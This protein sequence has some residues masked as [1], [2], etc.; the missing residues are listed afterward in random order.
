MS[1]PINSTY[2]LYQVNY[3]R[4]F[5]IFGLSTAPFLLLTWS[6]KAL[7]QRTMR[8]GLLIVGFWEILFW[9][10]EVSS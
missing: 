5:S 10:M 8:S 7:F 2:F 4:M 9:I 3:Y 6:I 1:F